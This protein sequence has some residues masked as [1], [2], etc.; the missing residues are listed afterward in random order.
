MV[1]KP[2]KIFKILVI[3]SGL[4]GL[5]LAIPLLENSPKISLDYIADDAFLPYGTKKDSVIIDRSKK[6]IHTYLDK[7]PNLQQIII[8]CNTASTICLEPLRRSYSVPII[9]VVPA[10][11]PACK[12]SQKPIVG[13]LATPAT[14]NRTYTKDLVDKFSNGKEVMKIGSASLVLEAENILS[15]KH[16]DQKVIKKELE[17]FLDLY[18]KGRLDTI[19]LGCTHFPLLKKEI[20]EI[21]GEGIKL[22]DSTDAII[23]RS[24]K[25]LEATENPKI[26]EHRANTFYYTH[27]SKNYRESSF[28]S[29]F[30]DFKKLGTK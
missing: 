28:L 26:I 1:P 27:P 29:Y 4:G 30:S 3:D 23:N 22:V 21:F 15:N 20:S 16:Y 7:T 24:R 14:I 18:S 9:G 8:G 17:P 10:L 2:Q 19:V 5:S 6:I 13:L 12:S 11:K 25:L